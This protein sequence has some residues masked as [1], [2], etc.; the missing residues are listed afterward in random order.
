MTALHEAETF[1]SVKD[2][3]AHFLPDHRGEP[4]SEAQRAELPVWMSQ[5]VEII[6]E[7]SDGAEIDLGRHLVPASWSNERVVDFCSTKL[8][9]FF[10]R[11]A[12]RGP[13]GVAGVDK[14]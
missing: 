4:I 9:D 10:A 2:A 8:L 7:G 5:C 12:D 11:L 6:V 14:S 13:C 1:A 3:I